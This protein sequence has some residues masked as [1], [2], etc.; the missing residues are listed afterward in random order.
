MLSAFLFAVQTASAAD[1]TV[2]S[3][4]VRKSKL[5]GWN[6]EGTSWYNFE[7]VDGNDSTSGP[8]WQLVARGEAAAQS[9]VDADADI[10]GLQEYEHPNNGND[11]DIVRRLNL[12]TGESW[13]YATPLE[14]NPVLSRFP[15]VSVGEHGVQVEIDSNRKVWVFSRHFGLGSDW[16][17][18]YIPYAAYYN[19]SESEILDFVDDWDNWGSSLEALR[20]E[21]ETALASGDP[22]FFTGD[23]NEPSHLDWTEAAAAAGYIP[24]AVDAPLSQVFISELG[25]IDGYHQDR[26]QD[27]EDE[28]SRWGYTWASDGAGSSDDD[29]IDFVYYAGEGVEVLDSLLVGEAN[30]AGVRGSEDVD[31]K[32]WWDNS[33][34][35]TVS[36]HR[37]VAVRF[38]L[39]DPIVPGDTGSPADT[40]AEPDTDTDIESDTDTDMEELELGVAGA[41]GG[42]GCAT[43]SDSRSASGGLVFG[44]LGLIW[45]R[46][47]REA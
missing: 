18:S 14:G 5:Y 32:A 25:M 31:L 37:A 45:R 34:T 4:N 13:H 39:P 22:V 42:C 28:I 3:F 6:E 44:L 26:V 16:N 17:Q 43:A 8:H 35:Y 9:I 27:G 36:D 23:F 21:L 47:S 41:A 46:R 10:V 11:T 19:Y 2:M 12:L 30:G 20:P 15:V 24:L 29:R 33:S 7:A 1:V 40:A 38:E